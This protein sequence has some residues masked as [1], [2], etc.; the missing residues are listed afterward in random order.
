MI[1]NFEPT[2]LYEDLADYFASDTKKG[3]MVI[4]SIGTGKSIAMGCFASIFKEI[5]HEKRFEL[6]S[7]RHILRDYQKDG[8]MIV[9]KYGRES[10][11]TSHS[12]VMGSTINLKRPKT[13]CFDD[14]GMENIDAKRYGNAANIMADILLDRYEKMITHGMVTHATTNL[15][16]EII[17]KKYGDRLMDRFKEMMR[18]IIVEGKS[19]RK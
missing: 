12:P 10:F 5:R 8:E 7:T 9:D 4:G 15:S 13:Y 19:F 11:Y 18:V 6:I 3:L 14:L 1:N 16:V 2:Q 17:E